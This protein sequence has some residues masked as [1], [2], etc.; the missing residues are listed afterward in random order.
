MENASKALII[1]GAILLSILIISLGI[2]VYN[3][4]KSTVGDA[5]LDAET[6]QT[7]NSKFSMYA[8]TGVSASNVNSLIEAVNANNATGDDIIG[9]YNATVPSGAT[10]TVTGSALTATTASASGDFTGSFNASNNMYNLTVSRTGTYNVQTIT[11][12]SGIITGIVISK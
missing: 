9:I 12:A 8:G 3:N 1:A 4:A 7:F 11:G 2:M 5:N 10:L 6:I